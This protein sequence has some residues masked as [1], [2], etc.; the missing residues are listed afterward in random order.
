VG[1][2]K[3]QVFSFFL[4]VVVPTMAATAAAP[5]SASPQQH[6]ELNALDAL[7]LPQDL[8]AKVKDIESSKRESLSHF[9]EHRSQS[10]QGS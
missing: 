3:I 7:D 6:G 1:E 9:D 2:K 10:S 5:P 4:C 8:K